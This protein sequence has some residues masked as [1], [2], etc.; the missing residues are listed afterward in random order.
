MGRE[1]KVRTTTGNSAD[2]DSLK[3]TRTLKY[4]E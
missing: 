2:D 4:D 3:D 1:R